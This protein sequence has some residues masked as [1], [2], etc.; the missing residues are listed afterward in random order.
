MQTTMWNREMRRLADD[1]IRRAKVLVGPELEA[2]FVIRDG[3]TRRDIAA[4]AA[5]LGCDAII[6]PA[7]RGRTRQRRVAV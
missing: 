6:E 7:R 3:S 4:A 1:S 2:S 5:D